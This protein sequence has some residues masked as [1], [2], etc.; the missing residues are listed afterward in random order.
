V[1]L[2]EGRYHQVKRMFA[3]HRCEVLELDRTGF[4]TLELGALARGSWVELPIDAL[5]KP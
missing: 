2:T 3:V 1:V 4:G 5:G